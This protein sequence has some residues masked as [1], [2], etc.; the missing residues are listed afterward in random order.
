MFFGVSAVQ[1]EM[2]QIL[3]VRGRSKKFHIKHVDEQL[4]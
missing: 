4:Q 1:M 3:A 2:L